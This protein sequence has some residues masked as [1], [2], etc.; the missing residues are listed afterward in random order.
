MNTLDLLKSALTATAAIIASQSASAFDLDVN[1]WYE[2]E[3]RSEMVGKPT[4]I[5]DKAT[6]APRFW[7]N[8]LSDKVVAL[9]S[10]KPAP[11]SYNFEYKY[12]Y[13]YSRT[14][15]GGDG[16]GVAESLRK[17]GMMNFDKST[18]LSNYSVKHIPT[19]LTETRAKISINYP[20]SACP[21]GKLLMMKAALQLESRIFETVTTY[22][23]MQRVSGQLLTL[24]PRS[25]IS[26]VRF[27]RPVDMTS[28]L[29][30]K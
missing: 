23:Q 16:Y 30:L 3:I 12:P 7:T 29:S 25:V 27:K 26:T 2:G 22:N 10:G 5:T 11:L 6:A 21:P 1:H 14:F 18:G 9:C 8:I 4:I 20:S 15:L 13:E 24:R 28:S 19:S 17:T